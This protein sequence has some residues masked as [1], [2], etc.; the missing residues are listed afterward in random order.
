L[1]AVE[2]CLWGAG[3]LWSYVKG[4]WPGPWVKPRSRRKSDRL[5]KQPVAVGLRRLCIGGL[6]GASILA[7]PYLAGAQELTR[8]TAVWATSLQEIPTDLSGRN[9][10]PDVAGK[11]V[12]QIIF[13]SLGGDEVRLHISNRYGTDQLD[14][15]QATFAKATGSGAAALGDPVTAVTFGGRTHLQLPPG[16]EADSDPIKINLV[17]HQPYAVSLYLGPQ[18]S[19][20]AWH[21]FA[22][23]VNFISDDG[24]HSRDV[25]A[26]AYQQRFTQ[27]TWITSLSVADAAGSAVL[28]IGDSI[29]DGVSST[30]GLNHRWP[31]DLSSRLAV[32]GKTPL[33]LLNA[34][35]A[36][37]R[38]LS[39]S[40]CYG[41]SLSARFEREITDQG[42]VQTAIV[43]IG[44]NDINFA[45]MPAQR[46]SDCGFPHRQITAENL[47]AGY[48]D[49]IDVAHRHHVRLLIGTLTPASLP[50][51]R[52]AIRQAVNRW[53]RS[54]DSFDGVIDFDAALRDQARP[55]DLRL[56]YDSGDHLHP[57]DAGFAA[58]AAAVPL[59]LLSAPADSQLRV[60]QASAPTN[61]Q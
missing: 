35:I 16:G 37:N 6:C 18:Q 27:F 15:I 48:R 45:A 22:S 8:W 58:M 36:G 46:A 14:V 44:I 7:Y 24:D 34:G 3:L 33:A 31:D 13:P 39:N 61:I 1:G 9:E 38:L 12:R 28:A 10:T 59:R 17:G 11:T 41:E 21:R 32:E 49:L 55:Q 43:L 60:S 2:R 56:A 30:L 54:G 25:T 4:E 57:S 53:I 20:Q 47:I 51:D 52:E 50:A 42:D 40:P 5:E 19:L 29:T 23:Q 26:D